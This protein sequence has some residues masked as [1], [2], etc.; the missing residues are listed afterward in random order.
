[1]TV[2]IYENESLFIQ[3]QEGLRWRWEAPS[4][5]RELSEKIEFVQLY[6]RDDVQFKVLSNGERIGLSPDEIRFIHSF[7]RELRPPEDVTMQRQ[8][9]QDVYERADEIISDLCRGLGFQSMSEVLVI[10]RP[11]SKN[12]KKDIAVKYLEFVDYMFNNVYQLQENI[13]ST[14]TGDLMPIQE[15]WKKLPK[16]P[17]FSYFYAGH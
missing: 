1:M 13:K 4:P 6:C 15:Y 7:V 12:I 17:P 2:L 14:Q 9:Q 8:H 3:N 11:D 10:G 16:V 5:P